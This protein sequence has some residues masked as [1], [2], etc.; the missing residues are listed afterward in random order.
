VTRIKTGQFYFWL[1]V[2]KSSF[3]AL[4]RAEET[5]D[6]LRGFLGKWGLAI[7]VGLGTVTTLGWS[8]WFNLAG[9]NTLAYGA[10]LISALALRF[11]SNI[12]AIPANLYFE[13]RRT[14]DKL[15]WEDVRS[16][17][18]QEPQDHS[19]LVGVRLERDEPH[20][21]QN[22]RAM[23]IS[24]VRDGRIHFKGH[25]ESLLPI[26]KP[27]GVIAWMKSFGNDRPRNFLLATVSAN[28][29]Q[30]KVKDMQVE[31]VLEFEPGKYDVEIQFTA[32]GGVDGH[33]FRGMLIFDGKSLELKKLR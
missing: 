21:V 17:V 14:S 26:R 23:L 11:L 20:S 27:D 13:L 18:W 32:E 28:K 4:F 19:L 3:V 8:G 33:I 29:M 24:V 15:S 7:I 25:A 31:K 30:M 10:V 22:L 12:V 2:L 5:A 16:S 9:N 1:Y 6:D